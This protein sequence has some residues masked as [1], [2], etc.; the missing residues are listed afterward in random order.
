MSVRPLH[1][2]VLI[3]PIKNADETES[4]LVLPENRADTYA[5]MQGEIVAVGHVTHPRKAEAEEFIASE[6][7]GFSDGSVEGRAAD[8]LRDLVRK[9]PCVKPGDHVLFSWS[10]GQQITI[11]DEEY[12]LMNEADLLAVVEG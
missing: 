2:R 9:E 7:A 11:D 12:I 4:G 6:L 5:E 10:A 3:R 8:L 1:D